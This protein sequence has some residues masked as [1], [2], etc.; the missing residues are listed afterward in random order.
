MPKGKPKTPEELA[1]SK[2]SKEKT[3]QEIQS[4][5]DAEREFDTLE[6]AKNKVNGFIS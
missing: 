1:K 2:A 4:L 5:L 6:V 3:N